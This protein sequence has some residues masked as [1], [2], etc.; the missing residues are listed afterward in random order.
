MRGKYQL[1][2]YEYIYTQLKGM[3]TV[4]RERFLTLPFLELWNTLWGVDHSN[5]QYRSEKEISRQKLEALR[6][7]G[8]LDPQGRRWTL[9]EIFDKI[10][11]G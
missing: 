3:T 4:E 8:L 10:G 2:D 6:E 1:D 9:R 7:N 11:P 5:V